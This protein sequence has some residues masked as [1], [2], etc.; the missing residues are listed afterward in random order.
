VSD[1]AIVGA[2]HQPE[3]AKK[4]NSKVSELQWVV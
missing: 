1:S 2:R 4:V 3:R